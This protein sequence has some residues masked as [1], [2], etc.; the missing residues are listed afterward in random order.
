MKSLISESDIEQVALSLFQE[1]GY[2]HIHASNLAPDSATP[3]RNTF[4]QVLLLARLE[5]AAKRI[6]SDIPADLI[7]EAIKEIQRIASPELLTN[8]ET[9][10]RI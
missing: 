6:N 2:D 1:L 3:E 5:K 8:N 7:T 10:H 4:E 9:F